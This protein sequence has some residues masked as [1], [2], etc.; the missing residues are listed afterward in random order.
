[1]FINQVNHEIVQH[2]RL[3]TLLEIIDILT[4]SR[5][6]KFELNFQKSDSNFSNQFKL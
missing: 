2:K 4:V 6:S 1:M 5:I 3:L